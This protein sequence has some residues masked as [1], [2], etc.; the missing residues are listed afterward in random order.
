[1]THLEQHFSHSLQH[2]PE[3]VRSKC[4]ISLG[5]SGTATEPQTRPAAQ[6][7]EVPA[8]SS[9]LSVPPPGLPASAEVEPQT[10]RRKKTD[11]ARTQAL[12]NNPR[13]C[14]EALRA[15]CEPGYYICLSGKRSIR[16]LHCLGKCFMVPGVDYQRF[17]FSGR[18]APAASDYD[19]VCKLCAKSDSKKSK[20]SSESQTSSSTEE[21]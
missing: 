2:V 1:M 19:T 4:L 16:T 9:S 20:D 7:V 5:G 12:G 3:H 8:L 15:V 21:N 13:E 10:D 6:V 14:R 11:S 17:S 18:L